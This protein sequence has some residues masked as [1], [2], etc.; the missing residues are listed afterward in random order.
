[1]FSRKPQRPPVLVDDPQIHKR[2]QSLP[3]DQLTLWFENAMAGLGELVD[4]VLRHGAPEDE[5]TKSLE[6]LLIMWREIQS[7]DIP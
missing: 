3:T 2:V 4:S 7:R 6:A 1:M 5:V